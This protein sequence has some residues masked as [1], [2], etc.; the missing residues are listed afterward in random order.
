MKK[1]FI[2]DIF[3][4]IDMSKLFSFNICND[5]FNDICEKSN[6]EKNKITETK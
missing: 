4:N 1:I 5:F 3:N 2:K 6:K